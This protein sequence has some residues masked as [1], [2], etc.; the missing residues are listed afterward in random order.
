VEYISETMPQVRSC[1][2]TAITLSSRNQGRRCQWAE[3]ACAASL[4]R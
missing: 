4:L 1:I 2:C 3:G